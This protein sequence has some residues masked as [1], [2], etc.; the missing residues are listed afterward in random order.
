[1]DD[2]ELA[3]LDAELADLDEEKYETW[4]ETLGRGNRGAGVLRPRVA[5]PTV[6]M[7][8]ETGPRFSPNRDPLI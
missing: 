4:R 3:E 1:M 5:G 6:S 7:I 2:D 8:T